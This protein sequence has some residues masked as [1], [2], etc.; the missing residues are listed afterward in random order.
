MFRHNNNN[1]YTK[2][3]IDKGEA[4]FCNYFVDS[5]C[6]VGQ[7]WKAMEFLRCFYHGCDKCFLNTFLR[8]PKHIAVNL[9][10]RSMAKLALNSLWGKITMTKTEQVFFEWGGCTHVVQSDR[11]NAS[12]LC[13]HSHIHHHF[14]M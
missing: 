11:P 1:D 12:T 6:E 7:R 10:K 5:Y 13:V 9:T 14:K 2:H 8:F 4:K 3:A